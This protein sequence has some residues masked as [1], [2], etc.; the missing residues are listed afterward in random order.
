MIGVELPGLRRYVSL[1][2]AGD[3]MNRSHCVIAALAMA[4]ASLVTTVAP[5]RADVVGIVRGTLTG[6]DRH[7][8]PHVTVTLTGDRTTYSATTGE[9]GRFAFPRIP[10]GRYTVQAVSPVGTAAATIDVAT[11]AVVDVDLLAAKGIGR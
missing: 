3:S 2:R 10:F 4:T 5:A 9:D 7:P 6:P 8:L 1:L 11:D